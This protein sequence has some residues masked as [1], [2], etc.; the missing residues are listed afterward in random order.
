MLISYLRYYRKEVP[1]PLWLT[2]KTKKQGKIGNTITLN[3]NLWRRV[4][5]CTGNC[6]QGKRDSKR[7][8][9]SSADLEI[10]C[11]P[12]QM[13]H[14]RGQPSCFDWSSKVRVCGLARRASHREAEDLLL[15]ETVCQW[16]WSSNKPGYSCGYMKI[17]KIL[18]AKEGP[19]SKEPEWFPPSE[20]R[21]IPTR[22]NAVTK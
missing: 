8:S 18:I 14:Q 2:K 1:I 9:L 10:T 5:E 22:E 20:G 17:S 19:V 7:K 4:T 11:Y 21:I 15:Q 16:D 12:D 3:Q 13:A 6:A